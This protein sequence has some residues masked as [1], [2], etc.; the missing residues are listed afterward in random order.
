[1]DLLN[2]IEARDTKEVER[3]L[4]AGADPN[5]RQGGRSALDRVPH[6]A[7][8]ITCALIEAGAWQS[9]LVTHM[10]WAVTTARPATVQ[11]LIDR[12]ADVNKKAP[13]GTPLEVAARSGHYDIAEKLLR[14]GADPQHG[15]PVSVAVA[16]G[17]PN[18]AL[19][20]LQYQASPK[21]LETAAWLGQSEVVQ[22]LL[23]REAPINQVHGHHRTIPLKDFTALHAAALAGHQQVV[24]LLIAG[25][26]DRAQR[27]G[28]GRLAQ[29]LGGAELKNLE[30]PRDLAHELQ[31]AIEQN[32][33]DQMRQLLSQGAS[34]H[35]RDQRRATR[36]YTPLMLAAARGHLDILEIL[37]EHGADP[38]K[39]DAEEAR[40]GLQRFAQFAGKEQ[41]SGD[42]LGH[43]ALF[44]AAR[45]GQAA[46]VTRLL[47]AG[48]NP[49]RRDFLNETPLLWAAENGHQQAVRALLRG[50]AQPDPKA[51][52]A[53]LEAKHPECAMELL[54]G[55]TAPDQK[56]LV[57]AAYLADARLLEKM[58]A[59]KPK[60]KA[61]KALAPIGYATRL[62]PADQAPPGRW[63]TIFNDKGSFK[64]VPEPEDQ[65]LE[66]AEVL[67]RA[68]APVNEV[69]S[70]G[71]ALYVAASQ[72]LTRLV[73]RLLA[74]GADP[75]L[76]HRDS[77]PF[78]IAKLM[79]HEETARMLENAPAGSPSAPS[80][81]K[82]RKAPK[83][84]KPPRFQD[85]P[86][87]PELE[88]ICGSPSTQ[89]DFLRGGREIHLR[90]SIDLLSLQRQWLGQGIYL[91]HPDG[92]DSLAALPA[93]HW[94]V[95]IAVMQTNGANCDLGTADIL[96][97]LEELEKTHPFELTTIAHDRL[98]GV[99]LNPIAEPL[100]LAKK[101]Y[102]FCPDIVDQGCGAVEVL[103]QELQKQPPRLYFWWD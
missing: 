100:K 3:L 14:G 26:A 87:L 71:P 38:E 54:E 93:D 21:G 11:A 64:Q 102:K 15:E 81:P 80:P 1:M 23:Q 46:A 66:A 82:I 30:A 29:E 7:D 86:A 96:K 83:A 28:E 88:G 43:T 97:W 57:Q 41:L 25:G 79:G 67:L 39:P 36:G 17:H 4:Q 85:M 42:T 89:P 77:T 84:L 50:G 55:G 37:L 94:R 49:N 18:I 22:A 10:V 61:G 20:L 47:Q 24:D 73:Q 35:E 75:A 32:Q 101:M 16:H 70:V 99:F 59:L 60:L 5:T 74:A 6:G 31:Q 78:E 48:A 90:N 13:M 95:A 33:P 68:G 53:A 44:A 12:G 56:A 9:D 72:G 27:D 103:A 52:M 8:A 76:G 51:L 98:E 40:A 34:P 45:H 19:L 63:T 62:V 91:F 69:S 58:L 92:K 2:A 65:I